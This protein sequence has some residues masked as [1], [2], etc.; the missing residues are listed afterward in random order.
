VLEVE[1]REHDGNSGDEWLF[2]WRSEEDVYTPIGRPKQMSGSPKGGKARYML[3]TCKSNS[4]KR[5][6]NTQS[7]QSTMGGLACPSLGQ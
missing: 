3:G 1:G 6:C 4:K 2:S 7:M 5:A